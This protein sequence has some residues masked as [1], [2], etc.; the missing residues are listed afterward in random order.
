VRKDIPSEGQQPALLQGQEHGHDHASSQPIPVEQKKQER[1]LSEK[2]LRRRL[3][4]IYDMALK[5]ANRA[6]APQDDN[7]PEPSKTAQ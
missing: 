1:R 2:E 5:A 7:T 3:W 4:R 6:N